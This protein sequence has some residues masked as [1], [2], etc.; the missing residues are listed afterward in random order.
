MSAN[1][2]GVLSSHR[3]TENEE[4]V[5]LYRGSYS[6][7]GEFFRGSYSESKNGSSYTPDLF[8]A[9]KIIKLRSGSPDRIQHSL[10]SEDNLKRQDTHREANLSLARKLVTEE[11]DGNGDLYFYKRPYREVPSFRVLDKS[12]NASLLSKAEVDDGE[13]GTDRTLHSIS[14]SRI[15]KRKVH[16]MSASPEKFRYFDKDISLDDY[17]YKIQKLERQHE[18]LRK[19]EIKPRRDMSFVSLIQD[20]DLWP[21]SKAK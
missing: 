18:S 6:R 20:F 8:S 15:N 12:I 9:N 19:Q 5:P 3:P 21:G 4:D 2:L 1:K 17:D 13:E 16:T 14:S 10:M 11:D 7:F